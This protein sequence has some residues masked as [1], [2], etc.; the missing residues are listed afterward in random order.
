VEILVAFD[1]NEA[2]LTKLLN[3]KKR[4]KISEIFV[5]MEKANDI[6]GTELD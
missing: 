2:N 4:L 1:E 3:D 6:I 5:F